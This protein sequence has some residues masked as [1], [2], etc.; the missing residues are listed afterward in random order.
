MEEAAISASIEAVRRFSRFYTK[1]IGVLHEGLLGSPFSL[2]EGRVLYELAHHE[3]ATAAELAQELDLDPS[4]LSRIL[5][6]F[7]KHNLLSRRPSARDGRETL[8]ALSDEGLVEFAKINSRSKSEIA[9]MLDGLKSG[10]IRLLTKAMRDIEEILGDQL[11]RRAPYILRPHQP[12]DIGWVIQHHGAFYA[13]AYGWDESFEGL[14]AEIA[15]SFIKNFDPASERCWIAE[16][17]GEPVG[18]VFLV[19]KSGDTAQLRLLFVEPKAR[20]MGIGKRLVHE[21]LLFARLKG[22]QKITL[23]TNDI[24]IEARRIYEAEG[25]KLVKEENHHSFG[26]N[27]TGQYWEREL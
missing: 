15:A 16:K 23:W 25:F 21:C 5:K 24:L 13:G 26:Q 6:K 8:L 12:G 18:S 20:G 4:Y 27:L 10:E 3:R 22:Y 9:A 17:D 1:K 11:P 19:R 2:T 7:E 14:V